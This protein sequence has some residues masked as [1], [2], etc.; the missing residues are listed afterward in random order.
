MSN[1]NIIKFASASR[2]LAR[3]DENNEVRIYGEDYRYDST[4][5]R[6]IKISEMKRIL[7]Q[8]KRDEAAFQKRQN[9]KLMDKI[10]QSNNG[11][12]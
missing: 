2:H 4:K 5:D 7:D 11:Y 8:E 6:F 3:L 12:Y 1:D 9:Q 10:N